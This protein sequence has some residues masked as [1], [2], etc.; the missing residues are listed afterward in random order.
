MSDAN[1]TYLL[2]ARVII[3]LLHIHFVT[4]LTNVFTFAKIIHEGETFPGLAL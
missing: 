2:I 1:C 3:L 4:T